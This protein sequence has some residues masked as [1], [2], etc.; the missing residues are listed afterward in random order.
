MKGKIKM[1]Q[2]ELW[3]FD[4]NDCSTY[5]WLGYGTSKR[6]LADKC[7]E[8]FSTGKYNNAMLCVVK[9]DE[10]NSADWEVVHPVIFNNN[11]ADWSKH[12]KDEDNVGFVWNSPDGDPSQE[13]FNSKLKQE[14]EKNKIS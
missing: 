5:Q 2:Y 14:L 3:C 10:E 12:P 8:L 1:T 6:K 7:R 13:I 9:R 11:P 4:L